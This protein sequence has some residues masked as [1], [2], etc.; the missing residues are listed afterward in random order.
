MS[1]LSVL[2]TGTNT[3]EA[4]QLRALLASLVFATMIGPYNFASARQ[5]GDSPDYGFDFVTITHPGNAPFVPVNPPNPFFNSGTR[6]RVGYEY[7]IARVEVTTGQWLQFVNTF[8][9]QGEIPGGE[10][11]PSIWG[12]VRDPNYDVPGRRFRLASDSPDAA[13]RPV[14][15]ITWREAAKYCNWL[16]NDQSSSPLSL[17]NGAYDA[18]TFTGN[19]NGTLNDQLTHNPGARFWIPTWDEWLKAAHYD[20]NRY[21]PGQ[22]GYWQYDTMSETQPTPGPPGVGET[23]AGYRIPPFGHYDIPLGAYPETV[24]PWGL[25]DTSGGTS[26]WNEETF[27]DFYG[28]FRYRGSDGNYAG[29]NI[30]PGIDIDNTITVVVNNPF[31]NGNYGLRIAS[32]VPSVSTGACALIALCSAPWFRRR[33]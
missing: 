1:V 27:Q 19:P 2:Q 24:S 14:F 12:A 11:I 20:P 9:T 4:R 16:C 23:S 13:M 30:D 22:E 8:W 25:L 5:G 32:S 28:E 3:P 7:R 6:G 26:E 10:F 18:A 21:G 33:R 29:N 17:L 31:S 15:G